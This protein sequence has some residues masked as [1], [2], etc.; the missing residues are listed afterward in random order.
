MY[1]F[2]CV[3]SVVYRFQLLS[4]VLFTLIFSLTVMACGFLH[5]WTFS[6]ALCD[7]YVFCG[8]TLRNNSLLIKFSVYSFISLWMHK[9]LFY[10]IHNDF[11]FV[12]DIFSESWP[13]GEIPFKLVTL[14][15]WCRKLGLCIG[16][17]L[18]LG[19]RILNEVEKNSKGGQ[20]R[21]L[22]LITTCPKP[23]EHKT[24]E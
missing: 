16:A 6:F 11:N 4:T 3:L 14:A 7:F 1:S 10:S 23:G 15:S 9:S 22:P 8:D 12:T 18:N 24:S 2:H 19:D 13:V 17:D 21:F 20:S 5:L